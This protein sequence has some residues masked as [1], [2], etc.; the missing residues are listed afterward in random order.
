MAFNN[1]DIQFTKENAVL[2]QVQGFAFALQ[3]RACFCVTSREENI[4]E[5]NLHVDDMFMHFVSD[6]QL[7]EDPLYIAYAD[8]MAKVLFRVEL[9]NK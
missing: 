2:E 6:S 1:F 9:S 7:D 5:E 4:E 3:D 8:M